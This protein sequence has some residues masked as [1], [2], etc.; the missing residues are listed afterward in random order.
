MGWDQRGGGQ[1]YT[2]FKHDHIEYQPGWHKKSKYS[3][4]FSVCGMIV[5]VLIFEDGL[6]WQRVDVDGEQNYISFRI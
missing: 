6:G 3:L 2:F 5:V 1:D 4:Q